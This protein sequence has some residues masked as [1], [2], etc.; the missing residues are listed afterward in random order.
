MKVIICSVVVLNFPLFQLEV[1]I[2]CIMHSLCSLTVQIYLSL[3]SICQRFVT[4]IRCSR[5]VLISKSLA[6]L[7]LIFMKVIICSTVVLNFLLFLIWTFP[8]FL[9]L[10]PCSVVAP[11]WLL[12]LRHCL[13][14]CLLWGCSKIVH[15]WLLSILIYNLLLMLDICS[16]AVLISKSSQPLLPLS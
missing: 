7:L 5:A 8:D 3:L 15:L 11:L 6:H 14:S 2:V 4:H 12:S 10:L 13:T 9:Q 16:V 1:W